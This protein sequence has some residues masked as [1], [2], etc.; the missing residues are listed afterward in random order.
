MTEYYESHIANDKTLKEKVDSLIEESEKK[1][2]KV[3]KE[4]KFR[5]PWKARVGKSSMRKGY[6]TVI[7]MYDNLNVEF[8]KKKIIGGTIKL[9]DDPISI[10]SI[11]PKDIFFY[12][13]RPFIL[14]P[15][16]RLN[17]YNPLEEENETYGQKYVMARI[18]G[19][20]ISVK[21]KMGGWA[22]WIGGAIVLGIVAYSFLAG[23]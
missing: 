4:K 12:K 22:L 23:G 13:G 15:K 14:Q 2:K 5:M 16:K 7:T 8:T 3:Y 20:K 6:A 1:K 21:K 9:D 17:P 10:H 11:N 18:E 19:D